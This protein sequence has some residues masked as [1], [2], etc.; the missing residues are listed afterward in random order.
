LPRELAQC[1]LED[2]DR[3]DPP[4]QGR[5]RLGDLQGDLGR[6]SASPTSANASSSSATA[7][8]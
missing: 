4:E 1:A 6:S 5:V 7:V 3:V 2:V 8:S